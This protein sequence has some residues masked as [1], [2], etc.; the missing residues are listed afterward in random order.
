MLGA[1]QKL[2]DQSCFERRSETRASV[3]CR[4]LIR[5]RNTITFPAEVCDVSSSAVQVRCDA[6]YGLL[7]DPSGRGD[8]LAALPPV[9]LAFVM[10]GDAFQARCRI[11]FVKILD[12]RD[13]DQTMLFGLKFLRTN[14]AMLQKLEPLLETA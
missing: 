2:I 13:N 11:K 4:A 8:G 7:I 6:K 14:L 3:H 5:C 10:P 12:S 1:N 9:E